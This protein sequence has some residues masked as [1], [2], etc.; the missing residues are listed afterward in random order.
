MS[1]CLRALAALSEDVG[2]GPS[3]QVAVPTVG[4]R[5]LITSSGLYGHCMHVVHVHRQ[6]IHIHKMKIKNNFKKYASC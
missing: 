2:S 3:T 1:Q 5:D 6:N 4:N